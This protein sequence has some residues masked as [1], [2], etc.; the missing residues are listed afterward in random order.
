[1][2]EIT[3]TMR[4]IMDIMAYQAYELGDKVTIDRA[5]LMINNHFSRP[6]KVSAPDPYQLVVEFDGLR[7]TML[8]DGENAG[9]LPPPKF[10]I[11]PH[12]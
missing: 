5:A 8:A 10:R 3:F 1:M 7:Y 2:M 12:K 6:A 4:C 9:L 11:E